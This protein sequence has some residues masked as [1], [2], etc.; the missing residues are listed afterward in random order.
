MIP[1]YYS[2]RSF[3]KPFSLNLCQM[4][5]CAKKMFLHQ[6]RFHLEQLMQ[7]VVHFLG[8]VIHHLEIIFF[9]Y[10]HPSPYYEVKCHL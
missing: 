9:Q 10:P 3:Q 5:H 7:W 1:P 2:L 4:K 8:H 6:R